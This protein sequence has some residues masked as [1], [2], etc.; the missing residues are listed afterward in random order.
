MIKSR[1]K[2]LTAINFILATLVAILII[3]YIW[4]KKRKKILQQEQERE[5]EKTMHKYVKKI[6]DRVANKVYHVMSEVENSTEVNRDGLL[7][8]C[9]AHISRTGVCLVLQRSSV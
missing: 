3:G 7:N 6:H 5:V 4:Y 9:F 2:R 1:F 8:M